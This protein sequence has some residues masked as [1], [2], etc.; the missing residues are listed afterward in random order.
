MTTNTLKTQTLL[1]LGIVVVILVL[2]N[3]ISVRYFGRIDMTRTGVFTLADASKSL[4]RNL[5]DKVT[6]KAFFTEDLP[7]PYNNHRRLLLDQLNEYRAY[8]H[9]N[10]QFD[11]IDPSDEKGKQEAQQQGIAPVQVQVVKEDKFEVKQA[12]MGLVFLYEDRKE[13]IPVVQNPATLE[14]EISSTIKR[15]VTRTQKKIGFLSGHGEPALQEL[16][17]VQEMLRKQY[18]MVPVDVSKG[19]SVPTDIAALIV[20]A[21]TTALP[22]PDKYQVDQYIMHGGRAAFLINRVDANLQNRNGRVLDVNTDDLLQQYGVHINPDLVR[23]LQC[24]SV[25]IV[26]QQFGFSMQSQVPFPYLPLVSYFNKNNVMVKDLRNLVLFF[27]SSV[28]TTGAA[29]KGAHAEVLATSSKESG[30][31]T[32]VFA[33]DPLQRYTREEFQEKEIPLAVSLDGKFTSLYA[34]KPVPVDTGAGA[35]PSSGTPATTSTETRIVVVGDGDFAR[36][37]FMGGNKDNLSFFANIVDYLVDDAGLITIRSKEA[38]FT[39]LDQVSDGTKK[40]VKYA[41]LVVPPLLVLLYGMVRWRMR[42]ARKK[43][44]EMQ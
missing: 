25:T 39:P 13:V 3:F 1:R 12:F 43:A 19:K 8:A 7:A 21:P 31:Q 6:I 27:A 32:G 23:D 14:Y 17:H 24:A 38:S 2:L 18:D 5:D 30:R 9:G 4:M 22:E 20:M 28:D 44:L 41:N 40:A 33:F 34:G 11:F 16:G 15:L 36:D 29:T 35:I 10:L 26:Q 42:K 37:Q